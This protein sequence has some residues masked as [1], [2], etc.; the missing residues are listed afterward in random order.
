MTKLSYTM[1]IKNYA[2]IEETVARSVSLKDALKIAIEYDCAGEATMILRKVGT[3]RLVSVGRG[4]PD[5]A[6]ECLAFVFTPRSCVRDYGDDH[7]QLSFER[8]LLD[9]TGEFW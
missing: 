8:K 9:S 6:Y 1:T 5:G 3:G 2:G 7:A 4:L